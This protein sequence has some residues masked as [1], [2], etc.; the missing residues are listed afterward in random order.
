VDPDD[1]G[2]ILSTIGGRKR[3]QGRESCSKTL[4]N[5]DSPAT[6]RSTTANRGAVFPAGMRH[7]YLVDV[8]VVDVVVVVALAFVAAASGQR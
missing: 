5:G 1:R 8:V 3:V 2:V 7:Q 4:G 6:T